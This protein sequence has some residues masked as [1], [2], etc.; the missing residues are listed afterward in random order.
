MFQIILQFMQKQSIKSIAQ[1]Q[2]TG[3]PTTTK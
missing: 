3:T 1:K 2:S